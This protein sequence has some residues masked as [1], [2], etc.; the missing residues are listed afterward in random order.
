MTKRWKF[1]IIFFGLSIAALAGRLAYIQIMGNDDLSAAAYA[2]QQIVLSGADMRG[3]IYDRNGNP[4]AGQQQEY[5]YIIENRNFDGETMNALN[6]LD[7]REVTG[8]KGAYRVFT[9]EN[10]L[11]KTGQRL[12]N[13]SDA[14]I[15]E[16]GRRYSE[17]QS[18]VHMIGYVNPADSSGVS[19]L[20]LQYDEELSMLKKKVS[21][22]ADING[23]LLRGKGLTVT[24]AADEDSYVKS[25]ITTTLDLGLQKKVEEILADSG[26][27]GAIIVTQSDTGEIL[28]SASTPVF[29]PR[30]VK[31]H[32]ES[33]DGELVN[34]V[35]Q[36]EYPPGSVFK[37]VVA[38]AALKKGISPDAVFHCSGSM[39]LSGK[40]VRCSTGGESGHGDIS[41]S[42]AFADSCNS[43]FIQIAQQTGT[44]NI[45]QMAESLGLGH[46][47]LNE[48]P[49]EKSGR[50]MESEAA[51]GAGI[52]NLALGQ[53]ETLVTPVQIARMTGIIANDGIDPGVHL[54]ITRDEIDEANR[55]ISKDVADALRKMM[56]KTMTNGTGESLDIKVTAGA[57]TGSAQSTRSGAEVVHGWMT[58]YVP[59]ESPEYV[60]T[61]F[62]DNGRSG[63]KSAGP[64]FSEVAD[65]LAESQMI[66]TEVG[67]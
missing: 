40:T 41:F 15:L 61:V 52:A 12:I 17:N 11:K 56:R 6:E 19:G 26:K 62:V 44:E 45:L 24:T 42:D 46:V 13:N 36:G 48:F 47:V 57:K 27:N 21:T 25:G 30:D 7:A 59:A 37:I 29:D 49:G 2:Q 5:I 3:T 33:D 16:A 39:D 65:Y 10:Y 18:A 1:L 58:G 28:A 43:A 31:E 64:L 8:Q 66:Q 55:C 14:Y 63:S 34:K 50:L 60:I 67:F 9:S 32:M 38:A 35:T 53:G 23:E 54:V 22:T 51:A 4:I 20:E